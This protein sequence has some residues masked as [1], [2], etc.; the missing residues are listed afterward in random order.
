MQ[1]D[2]EAE[3]NM[4]QLVIK[5]LIECGSSDKR[6]SYFHLNANLISVLGGRGAYSE[7]KSLYWHRN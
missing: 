2:H 4:T 3:I 5:N 1:W 7:R 6:S